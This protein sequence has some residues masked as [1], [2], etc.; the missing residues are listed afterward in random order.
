[1]F[2]FVGGKMVDKLLEAIDMNLLLFGQIATSFFGD[3][4]NVR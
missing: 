4:V 1:V 3:Q 2:F